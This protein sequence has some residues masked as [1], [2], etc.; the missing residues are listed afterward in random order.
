MNVFAHPEAFAEPEKLLAA[1]FSSS[2]V[3]VCILDSGLRYLVRRAY[4]GS[5][6]VMNS[7]GEPVEIDIVVGLDA[8]RYFWKA[9]TPEGAAQ[10]LARILRLPGTVNGHAHSFQTLLRVDLLRPKVL[11]DEGRP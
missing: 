4:G 1:Y 11:G 2:T 3:G 9:R 7:A 10:D 8:L 6:M 5:A